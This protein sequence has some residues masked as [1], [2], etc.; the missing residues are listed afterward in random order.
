MSGNKI[1]LVLFVA[2]FLLAA[3]RTVDLP[4]AYDFKASQ[5]GSNPYGCWTFV[6]YQTPGD[7]LQENKS[8]GELICIA[9]DTL[10]LLEPGNQIRKIY[11]GNILKANLVTHRNQAGTYLLSTGILMIPSLIGAAAIPDGAAFF[12]VIAAPVFLVGT[13]LVLIENFSHGNILQFPGKHDLKSFASC[14]RFP[15]GFPA[16]IDLTQLR[17]KTGRE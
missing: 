9:S 11:S 6:T 10:Y 17:L 14:S 16:G 7:S 15:A 4:E 12:L 2:G 3:C 8:K 1:T 13:S 5:I